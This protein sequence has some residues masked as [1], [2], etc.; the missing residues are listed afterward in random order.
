M[1]ACLCGPYALCG[2]NGTCLCT[3]GFS[4]PTCDV[5][6]RDS[7]PTEFLVSTIVLAVLLGCLCVLGVLFFL[8]R[9][10]L[11]REHRANV[12]TAGL[13]LVSVGALC[14]CLFWGINPWGLRF[15]VTFPA[16]VAIS[17]QPVLETSFFSFAFALNVGAM[18]V[19][20][21]NKGAFRWSHPAVVILM[22]V[23]SVLVLLVIIFAIL[24]FTVSGVFRTIHFSI[25]GGECDNCRRGACVCV[26]V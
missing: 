20:V 1:A 7:F 21:T 25:L 4:G 18:L 12:N 15:S 19:A 24:A 13:L 16:L 10:W 23:T 11:Q 17:L 6:L 22:A 14:G 9:V 3:D 26:C 2:A 8:E 5:S